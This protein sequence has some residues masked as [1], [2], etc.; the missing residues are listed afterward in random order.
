MDRSQNTVGGVAAL[1]GL[2]AVAA[3]ASCCVLPMTL[4]A[5]GL[6]GLGGSVLA[7][8]AGARTAA[9]VVAAIALAGGWALW[10]RARARCRRGACEETPSRTAFVL[11]AGASAL[12]VLALA[13]SPL[14][15]PFALRELLAWRT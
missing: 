5:V 4:A 6:G 10:L 14:V 9:T 11:L 13:W 2:A 1:T 3:W 15:E 7:R 8:A 12:L